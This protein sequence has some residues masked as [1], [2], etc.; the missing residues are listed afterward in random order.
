MKR[1]RVLVL[2]VSILLGSTMCASAITTAKEGNIIKYEES[3]ESNKTVQENVKVNSPITI[4]FEEKINI[5]DKNCVF[6]YEK[7]SEKNIDVN[8]SFSENE[9]ELIITPK[10]DLKNEIEYIVYI[11]NLKYKDSNKYM[12][13]MY[14]FKT[15]KYVE[16]KE[17]DKKKEDKKDVVKKEIND[18][19]FKKTGVEK[20]LS[21]EFIDVEDGIVYVSQDSSAKDAIRHYKPENNYFDD[22]N[23]PIYN[24]LKSRL[25]DNERGNYTRAVYVKNKTTNYSKVAILI[26]E[27]KRGQF[28]LYSF[29]FEEK[30]ID[31]DIN[32][33]EAPIWM[34]VNSLYDTNSEVFCDKHYVDRL[35]K[36]L[37]ALFGKEGVDICDYVVSKYIYKSNEDKYFKHKKEF[38]NITVYS[39]FKEGARLLDFFFVK[40]DK[41]DK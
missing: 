1:L 9:K 21:T 16:K 14:S 10:A 25:E 38:E 28:P 31:K 27:S 3:K 35:K 37:I 15:E 4:K 2:S 12:F 5:K 11:M 19:I 23:E 32:P 39:E 8:I 34:T 13:D 41:G 36:D 30:N 33:Y 40:N 29:D 17:E 22:I 18:E 26:S 7:E 6:V 20:Y 24:L